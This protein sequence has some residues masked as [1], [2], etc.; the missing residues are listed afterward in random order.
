MPV[1]KILLLLF[2]TVTYTAQAQQ[3]AQKFVQETHYLLYLPDGYTSDTATRFPLMIFLHGSGE[4][5]EDLAKVKVHGPPKMIDQGRKFPFIVVSPQ[6]PPN[7]G[8]QTDRMEA[9]L[10]DIK[11]KYRVDED[12]IYLT[13]LSMGGFGTWNWAAKFPNEF[14]AI[15]PICGGGDASETWK[16]RHVPVWCF[17]GAKD[18]VVPLSSSQRMV[19]S[20]KKYSRDVRFTVY[21][22]AN[23]NS[24]DTTYN[25]DSL[26]SWLL[27]HKKFRF[28]EVALP[29][30]KLKAY[31]GKYVNAQ[32]D[33]V[34]IAAEEGKLYA[35]PRHEKLLLKAAS[36]DTF[37]LEEN[38]PVEVRFVKNDP[39][40][41]DHFVLLT[42]DIIVF[43]KLQVPRRKAE[44]VR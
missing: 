23:H 26:Y 29:E 24:W 8:W 17:H 31:E 37:F 38:M 9:M 32:K 44:G 40:L 21:P 7:T 2:I 43:R 6:A 42:G 4:S 16:L 28:K 20:L 19:D 35:K 25:N 18:D 11:K 12:R 1:K 41:G 39:Q 3:T 14:A 33:T 13:G 10:N 27:S 5:G 22:E 34:I 36:N 30:T 15:A